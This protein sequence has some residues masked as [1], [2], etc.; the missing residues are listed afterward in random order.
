[1]HAANELTSLASVGES[2]SMRELLRIEHC[3]DLPDSETARRWK[4]F[5][6]SFAPEPPWLPHAKSG[7]AS[8]FLWSVS[9]L[10]VCGASKKMAHCEPGHDHVLN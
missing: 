4:E 10:A 8:S 5:G 9:V 3:R 2:K 7:E 1:M 6:V